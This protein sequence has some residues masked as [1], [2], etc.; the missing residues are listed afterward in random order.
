MHGQGV[1]IPRP[2]HNERQKHPKH[3]ECR[4]DNDD[5]STTVRTRAP[6][7][8]Y[9][10]RTFAPGG[11]LAGVDPTEALT[12]RLAG[13]FA[14][15]GLR[16]AVISPGSRSTPLATAFAV[17]NRITCHVVHDERSAGFFALGIPSRVG[18]L[19]R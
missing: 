4:H 12:T 15:L 7:R 10:S 17:E 3:D 8:Q 16:H 6:S 2:K 1:G 13:A 14:D 9:G 19:P 18:S 5:Q 11:N